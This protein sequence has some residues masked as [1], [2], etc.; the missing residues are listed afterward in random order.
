MCCSFCFKKSPGGSNFVYLS[1]CLC[2][3]CSAVIGVAFMCLLF[4]DIVP[5]SW[6]L[7]LCRIS[8]CDGAM[9]PSITVFA[10]DSHSR[11][12]EKKSIISCNIIYLIIFVCLLTNALW[13]SSALSILIGTLFIIGILPFVRQINSSVAGLGIPSPSGIILICNRV[14]CISGL[15][16]GHFFFVFY[17]FKSDAC[18]HLTIALV[19]V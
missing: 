17:L 6:S 10:L 19:V 7:I 16:S 12:Y 5:P 1:S 4:L 15:V 8:Y 18:F 2:S 9:G 13:H 3:Y 14:R 11:P